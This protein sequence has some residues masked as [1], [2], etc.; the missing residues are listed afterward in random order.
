MAKYLTNFFPKINHLIINLLADDDSALNILFDH[1]DSAN[2]LIN[3][4]IYG[5]KKV[6]D[7]SLCN[8]LNLTSLRILN[9]S[10]YDRLTDLGV[11][12]VSNLSNLISLN[13]TM[14]SAITDSSLL[15]ISNLIKL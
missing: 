4:N 13:L 3:L 12:F 2:N 6:M 8:I 10:F 5:S 11:S 1:T 7:S 15:Y 9:I 14:S